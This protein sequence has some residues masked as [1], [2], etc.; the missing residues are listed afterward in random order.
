M[1]IDKGKGA[2]IFN[3]MRRRANKWAAWVIPAAVVWL[4][5][6]GCRQSV[7]GVPLDG[8]NTSD[9]QIE[10]TADPNEPTIGPARWRVTLTDTAGA[11]VEGASVALRGDMTHAGMAPVEAAA[12]EQGDGVYLANF[13][14]TM[15]GDWIVTVTAG[16]PDG[17]AATGAFAYSV[18][19]A[20]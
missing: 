17:R 3:K 13:E 12:T 14:W 6:T 19:P 4:L 5:L 9:L 1:I 11:P 2:A 20:N 7:G 10:L 16:L 8:G 15:A 18:S